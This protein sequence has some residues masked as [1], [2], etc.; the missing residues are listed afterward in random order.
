MTPSLI[1]TCNPLS[2]EHCDVCRNRHKLVGQAYMPYEKNGPLLSVEGVNLNYGNKP[3]LR[4]VNVKIRKMLRANMPTGRVIA[5]LG[6][7]E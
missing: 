1:C 6:L 3:V 5:F 2:D 7:L 4:D